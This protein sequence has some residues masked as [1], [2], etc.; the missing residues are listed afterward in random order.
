MVKDLYLSDFTCFAKANL[1]FCKGINVF[2]GRN[3]TGKTHILKCLA[4]S[5]KAN[6]AFAHSETKS[7]DKFGDLF[8]EKLRGYFKPDALGHLV[9]KSGTGAATVRLSFSGTG[10]LE[11]SFGEK[12]S[13]AKTDNN[14]HIDQPH[15]VYIPP[16]EMLSL[17]DGFISLYEKREISFDET[18]LDLAKA[19]DVAPL[20]NAALQE[21]RDMLSPVLA[22]WNIEVVRRGNQFYVIEHGKEYVGT[23]SALWGITAG[24]YLATMGPKGMEEVGETIMANAQYAAEKVNEIPGVTANPFGSVFFKEFV[25]DFNKTGKTVAEINKALLEKGIF[26]GKDLSKDFPALGQSALYCVTEVHTA[27][28]IQTLVDALKEI[29]N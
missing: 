20:R 4:A 23:Q 13:L 6:A 27:E 1:H 28:D 26:G 22:K 17:F 9:N 7:K 3:G 15:F 8:T 29:L 2:I 25:V 19:L 14:A 12:A 5:M 11:Y 16:R 18:Y 10:V 24:V 21:A